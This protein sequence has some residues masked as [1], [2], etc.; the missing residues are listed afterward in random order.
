[1]SAA[2][3]YSLD[4]FRSPSNPKRLEL[5]R[6][7]ARAASDPSADARPSH[8]AAAGGTSRGT[9]SAN[10]LDCSSA[11]IARPL[12][13]KRAG[14]RSYLAPRE[15]TQPR[16]TGASRPAEA[17]VCIPAH[18][19][20]RSRSRQQRTDPHAS[21]RQGRGHQTGHR[22]ICIQVHGGRRK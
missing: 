3:Y 9:R 15:K 19:H 4:R 12:L 10:G 8:G 11:V 16:E 7:R 17:C 6:Q 22:G 14:G 21:P 5:G 1:M 2:A 20:M 18:P 13:H